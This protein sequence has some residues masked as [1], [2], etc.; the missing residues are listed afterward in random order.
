MDR[1]P[2]REEANYIIGASCLISS[3]IIGRTSSRLLGRF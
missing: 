2:T 1:T 3:V